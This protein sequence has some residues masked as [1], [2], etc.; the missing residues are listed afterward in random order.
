MLNPTLFKVINALGFQL[1]WWACVLGAVNGIA[2]LGPLTLTLFLVFH[3]KQYPAE[4]TPV[5]I[6]GMAGFVIDSVFS[7]TGLIVYAGAPTGFAPIWIIAMW[8]G[9]AATMNHSMFWLSGKHW[10]GFVMGAIFGPLAYMSGVALQALS[11]LGSQ[12]MT[13][14]ILG[15]VWGLAVPLLSNLATKFRSEI[16]PAE[17]NN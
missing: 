16:V 9:F 15:I 14:F 12:T 4:V 1:V 5:V 8:M 13:L 17:I 2:F 6:A 11:F 10:L 3:F 7:F